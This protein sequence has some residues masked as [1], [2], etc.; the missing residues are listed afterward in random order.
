MLCCSVTNTILIHRMLD[1]ALFC[2]DDWV[3]DRPCEGA[4][5]QSLEK[6]TV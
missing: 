2:I 4:G 3:L 6:A 1:T 5:G